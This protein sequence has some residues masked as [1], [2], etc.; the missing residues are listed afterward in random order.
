MPSGYWLLLLVIGSLP[1]AR[2]A[3]PAAKK[4]TPETMDTVLF[5]ELNVT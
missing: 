2:S 4:L 1:E 3:K 5:K